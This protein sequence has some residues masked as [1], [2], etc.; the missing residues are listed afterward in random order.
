MLHGA[1]P[2][3][4]VLASILQMLQALHNQNSPHTSKAPAGTPL[5][6]AGSARAG[7]TVTL[8]TPTQGTDGGGGGGGF[9]TRGPV[10]VHSQGTTSTHCTPS[11]LHPPPTPARIKSPSAVGGVAE[12]SPGT[13]W[14]WERPSPTF[15][16]TAHTLSSGPR[17]SDS[18]SASAGSAVGSQWPSPSP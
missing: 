16:P 4:A 10:G 14:R 17:R 15:S 3:R 2:F 1:V 9:P 12:R 7:K 11:K 8:G 13:Q 6:F 18:S 5:P